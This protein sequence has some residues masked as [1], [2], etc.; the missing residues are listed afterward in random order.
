M[1]FYCFIFM[2]VW[3]LA[4]STRGPQSGVKTLPSSFGVMHVSFRLNQKPGI[5]G[6]TEI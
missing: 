6:W 1:P 5:A 3:N 4:I 2:V